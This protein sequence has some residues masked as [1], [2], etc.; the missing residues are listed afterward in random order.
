MGRSSNILA[1]M[2]KELKAFASRGDAIQAQSRI[3]KNKTAPALSEAVTLLSQGM[4]FN[5][6][7][8]LTAVVVVLVSARIARL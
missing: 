6:L 3:R 5:C 2:G 4:G 7:A 1:T 8:L